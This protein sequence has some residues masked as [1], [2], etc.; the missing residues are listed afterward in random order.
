MLGGGMRQVGVV[1]AAGLIALDQMP[2]RLHEDHEH[3]R[4]LAEA[5]AELDLFS[6]DLACVQTNIIVADVVGISSS[7]LVEELSRHHILIVP[8][9]P[10]Q[11]RLV[12]HRDVN[13]QE[14]Y[15]TIRTLRQI[16][17]ELNRLSK[18]N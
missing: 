11:V 5:M 16:D 15:A 6:V 8:T 7:D 14:I 13:R 3:A 1:A 12:T 10:S 18:A 2:T 4:V 9:G 17:C